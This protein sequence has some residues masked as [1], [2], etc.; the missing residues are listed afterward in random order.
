MSAIHSQ[1]RVRGIRSVSATPRP[2]GFFLSVHHLLKSHEKLC[3]D[4]CPAPSLRTGKVKDGFV[5]LRRPSL[6]L[7]IAFLA[8]LMPAAAHACDTWIVER[9]SGNWRGDADVRGEPDDNV[10]NVQCRVVLGFNNT[11][12]R[13]ETAGR[14]VSRKGSRNVSGWMACGADGTLSGP[15]VEVAGPYKVTDASGR[16]EGDELVLTVDSANF[17]NGKARRSVMTVS[18][19]DE[20]SMDI[21]VFSR[22]SDG[23]PAYE[24]AVIRLNRAE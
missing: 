6:I 7:G 13:F 2:V 14:C 12:Q 17:N 5:L 11:D 3:V 1:H 20:E 16:R 15:L 9:L 21:S 10:E 18:F 22:S 19:A 24:S 4:V 8:G 23:E